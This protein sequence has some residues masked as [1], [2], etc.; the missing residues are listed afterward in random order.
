MVLNLPT[1]GP[2]LLEAL[3][4]QDMYMAGSMSIVSLS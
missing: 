3:M 4:N 1:V 2:L